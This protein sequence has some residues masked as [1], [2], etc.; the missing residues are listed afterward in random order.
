L[1]SGI[2]FANSMSVVGPESAEGLRTGT[3]TGMAVCHSKTPGVDP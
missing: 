3:P 2:R 1:K